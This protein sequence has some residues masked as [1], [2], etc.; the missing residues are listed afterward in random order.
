[1][2]YICGFTFAPFCGAGVLDSAMEH[3]KTP[4]RRKSVI[5]PRRQ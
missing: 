5:H 3:R 4:I 2:E 1:M